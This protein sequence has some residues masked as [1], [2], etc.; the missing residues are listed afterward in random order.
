MF[1]IQLKKVF[2]HDLGTISTSPLFTAASGALASCAA[3]TYHWSVSQGSITTPPRS[4]NGV[5]MVRGSESSSSRSPSFSITWGMRKPCSFIRR[6]TSSRAPSTPS[7]LKRCRPRNS[8]GTRASAVWQT[9][10][11]A[12]SM[13][14]MAPGAMPARLPTSKSLKSWPGVILTAP[15]PSSGSACSSATIFTRR[16]VIGRTTYLPTSLV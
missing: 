14:S 13:V 8:S 11:P 6:T 16:P 7:R 4:P 12:S 5:A 15:L 10:A 9:S 3:S 2:S 1:S